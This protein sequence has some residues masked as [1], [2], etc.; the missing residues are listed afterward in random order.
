M[1]PANA[2]TVTLV[3]LSVVPV[4]VNELGPAVVFTQT[5]PKAV[6]AVAVNVGEAAPDGVTCAQVVPIRSSSNSINGVPVEATCL[7]KNLQHL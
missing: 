5:L 7:K 2:P 6:N 4:M 3:A 1:N